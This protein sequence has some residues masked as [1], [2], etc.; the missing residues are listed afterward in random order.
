M[1]MHHSNQVIN[2]HAKKTLQTLYLPIQDAYVSNIGASK[3]PRSQIVVCTTACGLH[4]R[5]C[6]YGIT[7]PAY[8]DNYHIRNTLPVK[9][10]FKATKKP[11]QINRGSIQFFS[12]CT[13]PL[14]TTTR[15]HG[16]VW[17]L[18]FNYFFF[19]DFFSRFP[20]TAVCSC[21]QR[22]LCAC[23]C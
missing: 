14:L 22:P 9:K 2:H 10:V 18:R 6:A 5:A 21:L 23:Q 19:S 4:H 3:A 11:T 20:K 7:Q 15:N 13:Y 16:H 1:C 12:R 8:C 17:K